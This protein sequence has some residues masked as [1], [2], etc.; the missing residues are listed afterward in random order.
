MRCARERSR[1]HTAA[2][3][4]YSLSLAS[5]KA[6]S[7]VLKRVTTSTGPKISSRQSG[8]RVD[9]DENGWTDC[10]RPRLFPP[11]QQQRTFPGSLANK[12]V[13][14][15]G[16]R[17]VDEHPHRAVGVE[18]IARLPVAGLR[19]QPCREVISDA[20]F[21]QQAGAGDTDLPRL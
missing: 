16:V 18:R 5:V 3:S 7:S 1:V 21:E 2:P 13:D 6:S 19:L 11:V 14:G 4:P 8:G 17:G 20:L 12:R 15:I 10:G 9:V